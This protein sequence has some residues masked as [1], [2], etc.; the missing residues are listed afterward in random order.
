MIYMLSGWCLLAIPTCSDEWQFFSCF[1]H[2]KYHSDSRVC[3]PRAAQGVTH[4][5]C[6]C[7]KLAECKPAQVWKLFNLRSEWT[8]LT[9]ACTEPQRCS[10]MDGMKET[11]HISNLLFGQNQSGTL[12]SETAWNNIQKKKDKGRTPD[13]SFTFSRQDQFTIR[14]VLHYIPFCFC[15]WSWWWKGLGMQQSLQQSSRS[16]VALKFYVRNP[17]S[18]KS[19]KLKSLIRAEDLVFCLVSLRKCPLVM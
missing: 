17:S 4:K 8:Q 5:C 15:S 12:V 2:L 7:S 10:Q 1:W 13:K 16:S 3:P 11:I 14:V 9:T 18:C 19:W 6:L